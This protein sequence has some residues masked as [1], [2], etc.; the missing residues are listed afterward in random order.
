MD[1]TVLENIKKHKFVEISNSLY[2]ENKDQINK[3]SKSSDNLIFVENSSGEKGDFILARGKKYGESLQ[4]F[5]TYRG[6]GRPDNLGTTNGALNG[7]TPQSGD[8][9]I[10]TDG[11]LVGAW[12]WTYIN[13]KWKVA[14]GDTGWWCI[15]PRKPANR[16]VLE[17]YNSIDSNDKEKARRAKEFKNKYETKAN[18]ADDNN[19]M[20]E[21]WQKWFCGRIFYRR[22]NDNVY[23]CIGGNDYGASWIDCNGLKN[24]YKSV[25]NLMKVNDESS[26]LNNGFMPIFDCAISIYTDDNLA[27]MRMLESFVNT[28]NIQDPSQGNQVLMN[29]L[30]FSENGSGQG[31]KILLRAIGSYYKKGNDFLHDLGKL[32]DSAFVRHSNCVWYTDD[33]WPYPENFK[34]YC[35]KDVPQINQSNFLS[36]NNWTNM[37]NSNF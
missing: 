26:K 11:A 2:L 4:S 30:I 24:N 22:I 12:E 16:K 15:D 33:R 3:I 5:N 6:P 37:N 25:F 21:G 18:N 28:N 32:N 8:R 10:S 27:N 14:Q 34:G 1:N 7:I 36:T 20:F 29:F 13:G 35:I 23:L 9:Y 17:L 19:P 31:G